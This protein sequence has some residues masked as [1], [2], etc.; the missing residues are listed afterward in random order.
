MKFRRKQEARFSPVSRRGLFAD[1]V[2]ADPGSGGAVF[3]SD[4]ISSVHYPRV[5]FI[6]G[7]DGTNDG[8]V[9]N[10]NPLPVKQIPYASGGLSIHH[11]KSAANTTGI[12]VKGSAGQIY[13][14]AITNTNASA[15]YVKVYNKATAAT[16]GTDTPVFVLMIPGNANGAGMV[17][18][19]DS[20]IALGTGI[21]IGITTGVADN[22]TTAPSATEVLVNLF[23]K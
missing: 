5:K 4:E 11:T 6:H 23:Y 15:R 9:A 19:Q 1:N 14:W 18:A 21:S 3:G 13:G 16:V 20:G 2:T 10:A 8:D 17:F 22:D 7:A 12:S